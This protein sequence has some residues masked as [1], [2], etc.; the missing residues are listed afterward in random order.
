MKCQKKITSNSEKPGANVDISEDGSKLKQ[1][2]NFVVDFA[3][4]YLIILTTKYRLR[5]GLV[6]IVIDLCWT[7]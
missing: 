2:N 1:T 4:N 6:L 7:T 5:H 3:L